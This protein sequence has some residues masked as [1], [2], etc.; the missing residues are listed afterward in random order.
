MNSTDHRS[1]KKPKLTSKTKGMSGCSSEKESNLDIFTVVDNDY[2]ETEIEDESEFAPEKMPNQD[3]DG[4]ALRQSMINLL[5]IWPI[6]YG[7]TFVFLAILSAQAKSDYGGPLDVA[8]CIINVSLLALGIYVQR[9]ECQVNIDAMSNGGDVS[10]RVSLMVS[11]IASN[12]AS[13]SP[14]SASV[15]KTSESL[16]GLPSSKQKSST[17]PKMHLPSYTVTDDDSPAEDSTEI[18]DN[19]TTLFWATVCTVIAFSGFCYVGSMMHI[20][21]RGMLKGFGGVSMLLVKLVSCIFIIGSIL[22][23]W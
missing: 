20:Y 21:A 4:Y 13:V 18:I 1:K 5:S 12:G 14:I 2:E 17:Q 19:S 11:D 23:L 9:A 22:C 3:N 8:L 6:T 15:I 16:R 10:R 7:G